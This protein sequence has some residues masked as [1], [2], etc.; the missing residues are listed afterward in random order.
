MVLKPWL[1]FSCAYRNQ[2][3]NLR[4]SNKR[5]NQIELKLSRKDKLDKMKNQIVNEI[6]PRI[7]QALLC[8]FLLGKLITW[9]KIKEILKESEG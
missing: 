4:L 9:A 5:V 1:C 8:E 3:D 6:E 7:K 2:N